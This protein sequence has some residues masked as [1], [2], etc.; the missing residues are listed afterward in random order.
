[1]S[2]I[3]KR[4]RAL[5]IQQND[6]FVLALEFGEDFRKHSQILKAILTYMNG[7][8]RDLSKKFSVKSCYQPGLLSRNVP[9]CANCLPAHTAL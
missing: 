3:L 5:N 1:M 9:V 2:A 8:Q 4:G 7:G 6:I